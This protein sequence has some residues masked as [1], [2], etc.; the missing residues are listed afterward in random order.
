MSQ[1]IIHASPMTI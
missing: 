1:Q